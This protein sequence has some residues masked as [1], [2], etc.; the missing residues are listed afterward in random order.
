[1]L[2]TYVHAR[3]TPMSFEA[4]AEAMRAAL[5]SVTGGA[6]PSNKFLGLAL[7]KCA[8]ETGRFRSIWN[9]NWGNIK[10]G[11]SY[12][13]MYCCFELNEVLDGKVVWFGPKGRLDK[14]GG[15]VIAEHCEDPP[16]HPQTRMRAH[17][18][19]FDGAFRYVD[20]MCSPRFMPSFERMQAGDSGGMVHLMKRA[21][22][23][24][25]DE[26]T[27]ANS[28]A[29]LH[30]EFLLKLEGKHPE[31]FD[32]QDHE[33]ESLRASIIGGSWHRAQDAIDRGDGQL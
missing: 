24:T 16:G 27:Y 20:F 13:G 12:V 10:A 8:L 6:D 30:R 7:A 18:N 14:R 11:P 26:A 19:R 31:T 22:Y 33:W 21:R 4:A 28:V 32:P 29:S 1:M 3:L 15:K 23:F 2:A 9:N 5:R 17:A 25:A